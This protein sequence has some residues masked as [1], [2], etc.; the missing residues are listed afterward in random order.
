MCAQTQDQP[1]L[2]IACV[3]VSRWR[4]KPSLRHSLYLSEY[5]NMRQ[6]IESLNNVIIHSIYRL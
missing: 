3:F 4:L 6:Y 2:R 1:H 5:L